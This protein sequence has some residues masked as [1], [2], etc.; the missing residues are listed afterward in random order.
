MVNSPLYLAVEIAELLVILMLIDAGYSGDWTRIGAITP[1]VEAL[2]QKIGAF[3]VISHFG[4]GC[5]AAYYA[6][7]RG[8]PWAAPFFKGWAFGALGLKEVMVNTDASQQ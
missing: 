5:V 2:L 7:S 1:D 3:V 6:N 8:R 4:V